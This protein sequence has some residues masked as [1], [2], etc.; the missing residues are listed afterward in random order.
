MSAR[1]WLV[2]LGLL[3]S[4]GCLSPVGPRIDGVLCE[5]SQLCFDTAPP[6]SD[7]KPGKAAR[8][9]EQGDPRKPATLEDRLRT[10][11]SIPGSQAPALKWPGE[12]APKSA[13]QAAVEQYFPPL[14]SMPSD[15][16]FPP[17]PGGLPLTLS[18]LQKIAVSNSPVLRQAAADV[19]AARGAAQQAGLYPNPTIGYQANSAGPSGGPTYGA[20]W[21]QTI[22]TMGKLKLA[23]SAALMDLQ[24]AEFDYRKAEADL[25]GTVRGSY[26]GVLVAQES[27]RANRGLVEL[28]ES[29]YKV[30][31][32]QLKAGALAPYEPFQLSVFAAQARTSLV[33]ARNARVVTHVP[34]PGH[35][36]VSD[37]TRFRTC[38]V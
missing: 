16:D 10:P 9:P 32:D 24:K 23:E 21:S 18:E 25:F 7:E 6:Q 38:R 29:V 12:K 17:G 33:Q 28:T 26:Y 19:E 37:H 14:P 2:A 35:D 3:A 5:R 34:Q 11:E 13:V 36:H 30:M 1:K 22:K 20:F 15:P 8:L 4:A 31:L 27:I